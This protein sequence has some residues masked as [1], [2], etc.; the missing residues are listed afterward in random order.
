MIKKARYP[1]RLSPTFR[2]RTDGMIDPRISISA[3]VRGGGYQK[4]DWNGL[5]WLSWSRPDSDEV[6]GK[7][8]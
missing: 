5:D 4:L 7:V 1:L 8:M 6:I 2:P 3:T